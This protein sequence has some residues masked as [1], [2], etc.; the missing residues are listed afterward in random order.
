MS[1]VEDMMVSG[2]P[3]G[4]A[5]RRIIFTDW[6][7]VRQGALRWYDKGD[8]ALL[9]AWRSTRGPWD[10]G[11]RMEEEP[12][13]IR[14]VAQAAQR[15]GPLMK[16][17]HPW[18]AKGVSLNSVQ[19]DGDRFRAW[20]VCEDADRQRFGAYYESWDGETWDRPELGLVE[21]NGGRK[22]NLLD[23]PP[24]L[25]G[26]SGGDSF[27]G[28]SV[29]E[30]PSAPPAERYKATKD[31]RIS[32][33]DFAAYREK[34]PGDC[35]PRANR[36]TVWKAVLGAV[37]PDG[38]H[39]TQ[40]SDPISVEHS[41]TQPV[42]YYDRQLGKYVLYTRKQKVDPR[43]EQ[44]SGEWGLGSWA[45]VA[46]RSIGRSESGDF[47]HFK[48]SDLILSPGP[49]LLPSDALYSN[50]RTSIPQA[51]DHHLMFPAIYHQSDDT[52]TIALVSSSDGK[53]WHYVPG[54]PMLCTA[55]FGQWD[56]GCVFTHPDLLELPDGRFVLPYTG[57][58]FPHKYP[59]GDWRFWPGYAVWPKGR[60]VALEA[61]NRGQFTTV[62]FMSPGRRLRINAQTQ[63]AGSILIEV[64]SFADQKPLLVR[65]FAD[66]A[67]IIGDHHWTPVTWGGKDDLGHQDGAAIL[68][69]LRMDK[70]RLYGLGFE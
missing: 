55:L 13:G 4:L 54:P 38:L 60:L 44:A 24:R 3:Y 32:L 58:K 23:L 27:W 56:G 7:F 9:S 35:H 1:H 50:C 17:E 63:R 21:Y 53:D 59:R 20:G 65:T 31:G 33:E 45:P 6:R 41:D 69:R 19:C 11:F 61:A 22:N 43:S 39:W 42:A 28:W 52:T 66:V 70:A 2:E 29:F 34:W 30:D 36:G 37:S 40:L 5:G 10:A 8:G 12:R 64:V 18:E 57:Y 26:E 47:R 16:A 62:A 48:P 49:D 68:L 46:R 67:P 51:P 14:L 25:E 15:L